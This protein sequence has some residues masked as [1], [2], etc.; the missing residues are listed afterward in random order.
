MHRYSWGDAEFGSFIH[1]FIHSFISCIIVQ[2]TICLCTRCSAVCEVSS[3]VLSVYFASKGCILYMRVIYIHGGGR[4][5]G[6]GRGE[7]SVGCLMHEGKAARGSGDAGTRTL[8]RRRALTHIVAKHC[9]CVVT[10]WLRGR[11]WQVQTARF[12]D[13]YPRVV[14]FPSCMCIVGVIPS[15]IHSF[16]HLFIHSYHV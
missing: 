12:R 1:T 4:G 2:L 15:L 8:P 14:A 10:A 13:Q 9:F 11:R 5:R 3:L 7:W 6:G 16:I